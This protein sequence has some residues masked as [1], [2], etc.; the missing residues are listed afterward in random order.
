[1]CIEKTQYVLETV[2]QAKD[3]TFYWERYHHR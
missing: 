1:M 2:L 3:I